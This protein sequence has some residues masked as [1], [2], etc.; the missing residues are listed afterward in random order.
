MTISDNLDTFLGKKVKDFN[1]QEGIAD[2]QQIAYRIRLSYDEADKG[3]KITELLEAFYRDP[4]AA[5][6]QELIIGVY[7]YYSD[8]D[9]SDVVES[10][11]ENQA[12][13]PR[14]RALFI[15]DIT[16]EEQ[17]ISWIQQSNVGPVLAAYPEL[18]Y[19]RVRGGNGL[20]LGELNHHSLKYL[21]VESGGL[22]PEVIEEVV[23]AYLPALE[24]LELWLGSE[25][26]GFASEVAELNPILSGEHFPALKYL[27]LKDSEIADDIAIA[28]QNAPVLERLEVLDLSMGTLSDAGAQALLDNPHI[29]QLKFIDLHHHYI[30]EDLIAKLKALGIDIDLSEKQ[31]DDDGYR[32]IAVSE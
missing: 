29:T 4:N 11:V 32:Y 26:Y 16:Y 7:D 13:L 17:E 22:P 10:L 21:I 27:G 31:K 23:Q 5:F 14:L 8:T 20:S 25:N 2:P 30:S 24:H 19:F 3:K 1:P 15:G 9:S 18:E 28:L 12:K 6:V